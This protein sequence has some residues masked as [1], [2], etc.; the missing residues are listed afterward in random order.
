MSRRGNEI[1]FIF[2]DTEEMFADFKAQHQSVKWIGFD[3][4]FIGEKRFYT[5]LCILQFSSEKGIFIID[6]L[7]L[8]NI[9]FLLEMIENPEILKITHA[10]END[11]RLL[12]NQY[13]ILPKNVVDVQI[14]AAFLGYNYPSSFGKLVAGELNIHLN[15]GFTVTDW[16]KR[17]LSP[18]QLK[19]AARDVLYLEEM[20]E[21]MKGKL[22]ELGRLDWALEECERITKR[23]YYHSHP[24]KE[25]LDSNLR[26]N[27]HQPEELFLLRFLRWRREEAA[28]LNHSKAMIYPSKNIAML[29]RAVGGGRQSLLQNRRLSER[30]VRKMGDLVL[31]LYE[32]KPTEEELLL[33]GN[34][35]GRKEVEPRQELLTKILDQMIH[36]RC[37]DENMAHEMVIPRSIMK[38]LK[39]DAEAFDERLEIGWRKDFLGE[40]LIDWLRNRAQLNLT[41]NEGQ[42][43][44]FRKEVEV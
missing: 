35:V 16:T 40:G 34:K 9:D 22:E 21:Q 25:F 27:L 36:L 44:F 6:Y 7:K 42:F 30:F 24:D 26:P 41:F 37:M 11:Y 12:F 15:K 38:K 31:D 18:K 19:Y 23:D 28:R 29:T 43:Q 32:A 39:E 8:E 4:E 20:W 17:P 5:E 14:L 2:I 33:I 13:N 3:T 1:D 10:G